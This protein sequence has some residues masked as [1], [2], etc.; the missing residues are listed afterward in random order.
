MSAELI[1]LKRVRKN[2]KRTEDEKRANENRIK[3]GRS[4]IET[5]ITAGEKSRAVKALDGHKRET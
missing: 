3:F 4:K 2:R 1:N 5:Q